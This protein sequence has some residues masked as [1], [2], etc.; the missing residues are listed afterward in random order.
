MIPPLKK[1]RILA[2]QDTSYGVQTVSDVKVA[3]LRGRPDSCNIMGR[4][5]CAFLSARLPFWLYIALSRRSEAPMRVTP[6][7]GTTTFQQGFGHHTGALALS[8]SATLS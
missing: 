3:L 5:T 6:S 1:H 2:A 8:D 7:Q 4:L